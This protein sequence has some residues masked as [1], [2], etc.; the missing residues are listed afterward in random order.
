[1]KLFYLHGFKSHYSGCTKLN[2]LKKFLIKN[3]MNRK[4]IKLENVEYNP[5]DALE[6]TEKLD[7]IFSHETEDCLVVGCSLGGFWAS[8]VATIHKIPAIL[9]NPGT[10]PHLL[11]KGWHTVYQTGKEFQ[12]TDRDIDAFKLI[13]DIIRDSLDDASIVCLLGEQDEVIDYKVAEKYYKNKK[14]IKVPS[15]CHQI[16]P[17][18]WSECVD[19]YLGK[20]LL[21]LIN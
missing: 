15:G 20:E 17:A 13:E 9:I 1:M 18:L 12:V 5:H 2:D 11:P 10:K 6:T 7:N 19:K 3:G 8:Y 14:V 16:K 4:D 21:W